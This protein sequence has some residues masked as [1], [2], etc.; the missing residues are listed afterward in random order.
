M[1]P[2]D[3]ASVLLNGVRYLL[4]RQ[5]D[6]TPVYQIAPT[7]FF[8]S[9]TTAE[10][11]TE[12]AFPPEHRQPY[13]FRDLSGGAGQVEVPL[14]G[15]NR[16]YDRVGDAEGEG[17]DAS[18]TP[19]GPLLLAAKLNG[20]SLSPNNREYA[21]A[22]VAP[23]GAA[24]FT[25]G[26][27]VYS[28]DGTTFTNVGAAAAGNI[29]KEPI[30]AFRGAQSGDYWYLVGGGNVEGESLAGLNYSADSGATWA[31]VGT[32][33]GLSGV[34][35][36]AVVDGEVVFAQT[37]PRTGRVTMIAS[38][39]DGGAAPTL[40][41]AIDPVGDPAYHIQ[42]LVA[43]AGRVFVLK[44]QEGIFVLDGGRRTLAQELPLDLRGVAIHWLGVKAWRG[45]LWVP[46]GRGLYAISPDLTVQRV[47]PDLVDTRSDPG[48][49]GARGPLLCVAGDASHLYAYRT[50]AF[51]VTARTSFLQKGT[52]E[53]GG[54]RVVA[55]AWHD[56]LQLSSDEYCYAMDVVTLASI[57]R[58]L[59]GRTKSGVAYGS[60]AHIRLSTSGRDPRA[61]PNYRYCS[62]GT[63]YY[64]RQ[65]ARFPQAAKVF[66][67][68]APLCSDLGRK[69]DG[70]TATAAQSVTPRY[71]LDTTALTAATPF[72]YTAGT[73]QT[74]GTGSRESFAVRGKGLDTALRLA[75]SDDTTT[76][77]VNALTVE[78]AVEPNVLYQHH[79]TLDVSAGAVDDGGNTAG[80]PMPPGAALATLRALPASGTMQFVDPWGNEYTVTIPL[81]GVRP[82]AG[83]PAEAAGSREIPLL[84]EVTVNEQ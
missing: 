84:V 7:P 78:Y 65:T 41:G 46:T 68:M 52:V 1:P 10:E 27:H 67:V 61:D 13:S 79:M 44:S 81:T 26:R 80:E 34:R 64:S 36:L 40:Y 71:K 76:P 21:G 63:L 19:D 18:L 24:I 54:G 8:P 47:G 51:G 43:F 30:V 11:V 55:E 60:I 77:Q 72:G 82:R 37:S 28:W 57:P 23:S 45:L 6:G 15:G 49:F 83:G 39:D 74:T 53:I 75:S 14:V 38:F 25:V 33:G 48:N 35:T 42:R 59:I 3:G 56:F 5:K 4:A 58:L 29:A 69:S 17:V 62:A 50:S 9:Q 31:G 22:M 12:A 32:A 20:E 16:R 66:F 73:A 2:G 70:V